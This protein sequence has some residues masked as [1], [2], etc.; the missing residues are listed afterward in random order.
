MKL[1]IILCIC[2]LM[3]SS[4]SL[5]LFKFDSET[6]YNSNP[7]VASKVVGSENL[8]GYIVPLQSVDDLVSK[9]DL[10]VIGEIM[11]DAVTI[12]RP[13]EPSDEAKSK[14]NTLYPEA[15]NKFNFNVAQVT[16]QIKEV[17]YGDTSLSEIKFNQL[18]NAGNDSLQT[19][20][21]K[22]ERVVLALKKVTGTDDT[23][24]S[25][26]FEECVFD[27]KPNNKLLSFSKNM[28]FA[29]YDDIDLNIL[30]NDI[31][32]VKNKLNN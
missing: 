1:K 31:S 8:S 23:Y 6:L 27:I 30:E 20:V 5:T 4:V 14:L 2:L 19:K 3:L 25:I 12:K 32:K 11:S 17:L 16:V 15:Q 24:A 13:Y 9:S 29:K 18:G 22:N 7:N 21:K 10:I 26:C 28:A